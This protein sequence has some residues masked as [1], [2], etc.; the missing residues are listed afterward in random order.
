M[1]SPGIWLRRVRKP[2]KP[3]SKSGMQL[4]R[5][6]RRS[7]RSWAVHLRRSSWKSRSWSSRQWWAMSTGS[8]LRP[9]TTRASLMRKADPIKSPSDQVPILHPVSVIIIGSGQVSS[10]TLHGRRFSCVLFESYVWV[11]ILF[12]CDQRCCWCRQPLTWTL[13]T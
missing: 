5:G 3:S 6:W 8:N 11:L 2:S 12:V 9:S 13:W 4:S 1:P 7:L 10:F